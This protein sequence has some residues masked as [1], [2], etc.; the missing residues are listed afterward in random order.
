MKK[1]RIN[2]AVLSK[3]FVFLSFLFLISSIGFSGE[4][5][6]EPI[7]FF[8]LRYTLKIDTNESSQVNMSWDH[9][10]A[11]ATLQGI[12]NRDEPLL[13]FIY[14]DSYYNKTLNIDRYW[15][16]KYSGDGQ[17]LAG[18]ER[19]DIG[20]IYELIDLFKD[21]IK[22][23]VV[24]DP[25]VAATSNLAS[26]YAGTDDLIAIR[27]D[28]S[29]GSLYNKVIKSGPK[30]AVKKWLVNP[31]G[32]S[33]FCGIGTIPESGEASTGSSKCDVYR[34][35]RSKLI[36]SGKCNTLYG[37][38]YVDYLWSEN[39]SRVPLNHHTL[40]NHD[41]FVSK[42]AFFFDL[43]VWAD[44]PATDD[45]SQI[46]GTDRNM[47]KEL[48]HAAYNQNGP[49]EI[50]HI[51]GFPCWA[52]KYTRHSG[53]R[54]HEVHTEWEYAL[55]LSAYNG[56][57]D[58][59][60]IGIGAMANASFWTHFPLEAKYPQP[61][62]SREQL[63]L[64]GYLSSDGKV[65]FKG[66]EFVIFYI[67]DYD[68][69][70]WLYQTV[71]TIWDDNHRGKVPMMWCISP[72]FEQRAPMALHYVRKSASEKD[73][74]VA[75]DNGAGYLN[76]S[77]LQQGLWA[78]DPRRVSSLPSGLQ[79]WEKHCKYY[80]NKWGLS[81]TGFIIDGW[82]A[83]M[84]RAVWDCYRS[85]SPNGIVAQKVPL[86]YLYKGMPILRSDLDVNESPIEAARIIAERVGERKIPFH[87]FR[88][89][90]K[91]PRWYVQVNDE[92]KKINENIEL[93]E[94]PVFFELYK[95]YLENNSDAAKGYIRM[96][97]PFGY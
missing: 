51:G 77:M 52:L 57:K 73:Y 54:H 28:T 22:G 35:M 55:I 63:V 84:T 82:S 68:A 60:A 95:I 80:Y 30:I 71:P 31:D 70:S 65:D 97:D 64:D 38:Y 5:S 41:F 12:V 19:K 49:D 83:P 58:A 1:I 23:A 76:P 40:T 59:D 17:W 26:T 56:I 4:I 67:G 91:S 72:V 44:E 3:V 78:D 93:L 45:P 74:F 34:F 8:D 90:L 42:R 20:S 33:K 66:R 29:S 81:V 79:A 6:S 9:C 69:S 87:W 50:M 61:W 10:H 89:I 75:P 24:Y 21:R 47:L 39:P 62:V 25:H 92:L 37:A 18:R 36:D 7:Y 2:S 15:F 27:Y 88:N 11:A 14:V 46:P 96:H 85:F 86:S 48:F 13:Y 16:D 43:G 53:G 32:S 94:A